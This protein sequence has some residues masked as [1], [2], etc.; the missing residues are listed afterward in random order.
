MPMVTPCR[1]VSQ[2]QWHGSRKRRKTAMLKLNGSSASATLKE[3]DCRM[4]R[5]KQL[6]GSNEQQTK[7]ILE[8]SALSA[9][10]I[11]PDEVCLEITCVPIPGPASLLVCAETICEE[12]TC[13][14]TTATV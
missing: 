14:I 9:I 13:E 7:A 6:P 10:F 12:M 2:T 4:T 8:P 1:T 3:S 5:V 11:S